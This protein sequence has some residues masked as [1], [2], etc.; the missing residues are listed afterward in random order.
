MDFTVDYYPFDD[1]P[2]RT[3]VIKDCPS[4]NDVP[5]KFRQQF[6]NELYERIVTDV[7]GELAIR[8]CVSP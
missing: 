3:I 8:P 1:R 4:I 5:E 6:G 7:K 2:M